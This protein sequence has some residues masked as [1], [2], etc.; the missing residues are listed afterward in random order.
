[1]YNN[2]FIVNSQSFIIFFHRSSLSCDSYVKLSYQHFGVR[3]LL[4]PPW[5]ILLTCTLKAVLP[6]SVQLSMSGTSHTILISMILLL[7]LN[8]LSV[9]QG[10]VFISVVLPSCLL[11]QS[12]PSFLCR[13][14]FIKSPSYNLINPRPLTKFCK[15]NVYAIQTASIVN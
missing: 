10:N 2:S 12:I 4:S 7:P 11:V 9:I 13:T 14:S 5:S 6:V 1:M 8:V 3:S 15:A